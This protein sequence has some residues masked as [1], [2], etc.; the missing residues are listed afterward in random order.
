MKIEAGKRYRRRDGVISGVIA[1]YVKPSASYIFVDHDW[2]YSYTEK[3]EHDEGQEAPVDLIEEYISSLPITKT[4]IDAPKPPFKLKEGF[5]Y[6]KKNRQQTGALKKVSGP[7]PNEIWFVDNATS[8][9]YRENGTC[10]TDPSQSCDEDIVDTIVDSTPS[11]ANAIQHGGTHYKSKA[12]EPWDYIAA[13]QLGY[14]EGN[15]VKYVSRWKEKGGITDLKKAIHFIQK[16]IE[17]EEAKES[18]F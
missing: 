8:I 11:S 14:F 6:V 12:I 9:M 7:T 2:G 3:G 5:C 10:H 15:V 4:Q 1:H 18:T 16:L 17:V 13:N